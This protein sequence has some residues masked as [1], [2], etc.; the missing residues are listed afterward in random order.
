MNQ[1]LIS[2]NTKLEVSLFGNGPWVDGVTRIETR[3]ALNAGIKQNFLKDKLSVSIGLND[4]F[5]T[6]P[7]ISEVKFGN[8]YS[9]SI[10]SWDSRRFNL[11]I[12]YNFGK[13]KVQQ[14]NVKG[15]DEEKGRVGGARN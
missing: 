13:I 3:G 15:I 5:Y 4:I 10:H 9:S 2:K 6:L 7:V 1:F 11:S 12:N 8:Q 14:R